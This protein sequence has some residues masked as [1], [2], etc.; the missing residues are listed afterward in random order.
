MITRF[1]TFCS[2]IKLISDCLI[3]NTRM[4]RI[5]L[6]WLRG[7]VGKNEQNSDRNINGNRS[8]NY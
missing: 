6:Q 2:D 7:G 3:S 8:G 1:Y 5:D 4:I